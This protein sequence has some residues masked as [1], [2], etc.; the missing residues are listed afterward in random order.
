MK[1]RDYLGDLVVYGM[2]LFS[3]FKK[4]NVCGISTASYLAAKLK[5]FS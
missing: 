2:I 1:G 4:L 3:T 5:L